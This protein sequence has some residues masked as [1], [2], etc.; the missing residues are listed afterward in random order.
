MRITAAIIAIILALLC[1]PALADAADPQ[2]EF[3]ALAG[4]DAVQQALDDGA[5]ITRM[6]YNNGY[7]FGQYVV[8]IENSDDIASLW[9]SLGMI[10]IAGPSASFITDMYP[11]LKIE[12]S[13]G[14]SSIVRFN[15]QALDAGAERYALQGDEWFWISINSILIRGDSPVDKPAGAIMGMRFYRYGYTAPLTL[16]Y[17]RLDVEKGA[18]SVNDESATLTDAK[19]ANKL[20]SLASKYAVYTWKGF[21]EAAEGVLDGEGFSL[22][23]LWQNGYA[24]YATGD[25]AFPENYDEFAYA[26]MQL[27]GCQW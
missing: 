17:Q 11:S 2:A 27:F 14:S 18:M 1:A 25:N 21:N 23:I 26:L 4:L 6:S 8:T 24:L 16:E 3:M 12:L 20:D 19:F 15:G 5:E 9:D 7:G 13:D 10:G 22:T